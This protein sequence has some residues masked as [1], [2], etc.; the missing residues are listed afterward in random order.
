[1]RLRT[2]LPLATAILLTGCSR[3]LHWVANQ[4]ENTRSAAEQLAYANE[5]NNDRRESQIDPDARMAR[6]SEPL[7]LTR[8]FETREGPDGYMVYDTEAHQIARI[9]NQSQS[10][11]T[12]EQAQKAEGALAN[13][14]SAQ[15][16]Q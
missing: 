11:L 6:Q 12:Y 1:M 7:K 9:G 13:P 8:R 5:I 10:G 2:F 14:D 16:P 3:G 4:A 15:K